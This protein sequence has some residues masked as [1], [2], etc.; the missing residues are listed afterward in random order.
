MTA[1]PTSDVELEKRSTSLDGSGSFPSSPTPQEQDVVPD[2][3]PRTITGLRWAIVC[4]SLYLGALIYGL[5][6]TIAADIQAAVIDDFGE[7]E[8]LTWI[9]T[10]FPLGSVCAVLP[11]YI[12]PR[13]RLI[14]SE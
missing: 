5:D 3:P 6:T 2:E 8:K 10:A 12:C 4:F 13:H 1:I 14:T 9:G 11:T 7:V